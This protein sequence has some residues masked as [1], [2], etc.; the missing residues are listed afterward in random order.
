MCTQ[1]VHAWSIHSEVSLCEH[2]K[3]IARWQPQKLSHV[4]PAHVQ[5]VCVWPAFNLS[6][7]DPCLTCPS[8]ICLYLTHIWLAQHST[9]LLLCF[10][11]LHKAIVS[12][13][14]AAIRTHLDISFAVTL[15]SQFLKSPGCAH[16]E[17]AKQVIRYLK[18]TWDCKL[19]FGLNSGI[20][21]F[22]NANWGNDINDCYSICGYVFT[23]NGGAISWSSKKQSV[24]ALSSTEAE[25]IGIT[26]TAKEATWICY[27]LSELY[28]PQILDYPIIIHCNNKSA[29]ELAKNATFHSR[30]KHIAICYHYICEALNTGIIS[31]EHLGTDDMPA[32]MFTKALIH[33]KLT[34]FAQYIR[35]SQTWGGVLCFFLLQVWT[36]YHPFTFAIAYCNHAF[37]IC[38]FQ[39]MCHMIFPFDLVCS[40]FGT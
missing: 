4:W 12:L 28:S 22:S 5:S 34:K 18:G 13:M 35:L 10:F 6:V 38:H 8:L 24:M 1:L 9:H 7:F 36:F 27:L 15:L 37:M 17:Q 16:W 40:R 26:H 23:L 31:L 14:Y 21:G 25:Y 33:L 29:I 3:L 39:H 20:E 32:D 19:L 30:T 11:L 2:I